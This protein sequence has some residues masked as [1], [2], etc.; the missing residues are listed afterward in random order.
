[1]KQIVKH[2]S[3]Y[4]CLFMY[5]IAAHG[6][7]NITQAEYFFDTDPG[8]GNAAAITIATPSVNISSLAFNANVASLTNGVHGLYI[9][10]KNATGGWSTTN[11]MMIAKVQAPGNNP[12]ALSNIIKAEYFYDTDPGFG[13]GANIA[14]SS[15][16]NINA[17]VFNAD[18]STLPVGIHTLYVRTKDAS[19][20]SMINR[21]VFA[22]AQNVSGN[23]NTISNIVKAEYFYD[24]DPG[25]GSGTD[26]PLA[27]ATN[28]SSLVFNADVT[29]VAPGVHTLY[30]RTKDAQGK[31]SIT[32][33][34][35][36]SKFQP[37][38]GNPNMFS[39]ITKAEYFFNTDPGAGNGVNIPITAATDINGFVVNADVSALYTGLH[40]LYLR[41]RDAQGKWSIT[42]RMQFSRIQGLSPNP[43]SLS[44]INKAEY[45]Y[46]ND[47]GFGN[48]INIPIGPSYNVNALT[49]NTDVTALSNGMHALYVRTRDSLGQWSL[50]GRL[51]FA[52]YQAPGANPHTISNIVKAEYF[53]D[54]DPGVNAGTDIPLAAASNISSFSFNVNTASLANGV[55]TLYLRTKDA[56]GKWSI[57]NR[58]I[59]AKV[60]PLSGNPHTTSNIS[61][62]E[63]FVDTDP[64]FGNGLSVPFTAATDVSSV[65]F[66]VDMTVLV[67][68]VHKLYVR[69]RD[70][71]GQWSITNIF[72]FTGGTAPL[73]VKFLAFDATVQDRNTVLL[74]WT[75]AQ[76]RN[77]DI[78]ELERS[79]DAVSWVTIHT[80]NPDAQNATNEHTYEWTDEHPGSGIIY[81]RL[82]EKDLDGKK[83]NA[84][85][86]FV[87]ID[88]RSGETNVYPNPNDGKTINVQSD[89]F[90]EGITEISIISADGKLFFSGKV[91]ANTTAIFTINHLELIPGNYFVNLR[92]DKRSESL[93]LVVTGNLP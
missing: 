60:Q 12:S 7:S 34:L 40:T 68:A 24:T 65:S 56:Q 20:W 2:M 62:I 81:Y 51:Y 63:Y 67:N 89:L 42:Q 29:A 36:F 1:M 79:Y 86:R 8:F 37:V 53:Y 38:S 25:V 28:I 9:R 35:Y 3:V 57:V 61:R 44:R 18:V 82:S 87:K 6:Q 14:I 85:I 55:H 59:F 22:K 72:S 15:A 19:G 33:K 11:R 93:K 75:T 92:N 83:T 31:W 50:A 45:F 70:L 49:F 21:V 39:N 78:Y 17:L 52:K 26:I 13:N 32:S 84:P 91:N 74:S 30:V 71:Q 90:A 54:T 64:G 77:V 46:D 23:P 41:T 10:T 76:E 47:P 69:S 80:Q 58:S 16:T 27:A 48:G 73:S 43:H 5:C 66:N 4:V 88:S